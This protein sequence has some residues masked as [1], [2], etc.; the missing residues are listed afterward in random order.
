MTTSPF[1]AYG[2]GHRWYFHLLGWE[3][4]R[5]L[6]EVGVWVEEI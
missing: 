6:F 3:E 4:F 5:L 1:N 2:R